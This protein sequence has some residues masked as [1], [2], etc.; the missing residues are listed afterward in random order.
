MLILV[1]TEV[2]FDEL[3][4]FAQVKKM[5]GAFWGKPS[6]LSLRDHLFGMEYAFSFCS[7]EKQLKYFEAFIKWYH[8][9][10]LM[11]SSAYACWWSHILYTSLSDDANAFESFFGKFEQYL[12]D[13]HNLHLPEVK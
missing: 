1:N 10:I 11:D 9:E 7:E 3:V 2:K 5:P 4:F 13:V 8:E 12:H 6:L